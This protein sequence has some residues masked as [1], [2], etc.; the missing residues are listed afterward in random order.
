MTKRYRGHLIILNRE[1]GPKG[2][3]AIRYDITSETG[4]GAAVGDCG[5]LYE[6]QSLSAAAREVAR[7]IDNAIERDRAIASNNARRASA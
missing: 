7:V 4:L 3:S 5:W 1:I 6:L 2:I